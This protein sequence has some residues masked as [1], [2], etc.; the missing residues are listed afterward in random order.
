MSKKEENRARDEARRFRDQ[1][2]QGA[3][4]DIGG[5]FGPGG[6]GETREGARSR[7]GETYGGAVGGFRQA[8]ETGGYDPTQLPG[9]RQ[10]AA[11]LAGTGGFDSSRVNALRS[12][13]D[14]AAQTGGFDPDILASYRQRFAGLGDTGGYSAEDR[15]RITRLADTGGFSPEDEA[16]F[17]NRAS[18]GVASIYRTL[19]DEQARKQAA[20]GGLGS[21][22]AAS[23]L[24]RQATQRQAEAALNAEVELAQQ[25]R[26]GQVAGIGFTGDIAAGRRAGTGMGTEL[27][28]GVATGR[29]SA[30]GLGGELEGQLASGIRQ[31]FGQQ[32]GLEGSVAAGRL[33][34]TQG[35]ASLFNT[36]TGEISETGRQ[37]LDRLGLSSLDQ[38]TALSVL[39]GLAQ[40]PGLFDNIMRGAQVGASVISGITG[41]EGI[42]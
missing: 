1:A 35:M 21:G 24:A 42:T 27:E 34:G 20:S 30:L 22:G 10:T 40:T 13:I 25:K 29:R 23:Q 41:G 19:Q 15:E 39:S 8:Q 32:A 12:G 26:A 33:S 18:S 7:Q 36:S 9:L 2:Q 14:T 38:R 5:G 28:T 3:S 37:I 4:R 6:L 17:R 31:G 11:G 16:N